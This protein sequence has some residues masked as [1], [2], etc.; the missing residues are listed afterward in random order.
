VFVPDSIF[1]IRTRYANGL[2]TGKTANLISVDLTLGV[3][4][5]NNT[6]VNTTYNYVYGTNSLS[7][8]TIT[9]V[10]SGVLADFGISNNM[11][12]SE[13]IYI[14]SEPVADYLNVPINAVRYGF[15]YLPSANGGTEFIDDC[16]N[17]Q[18]YT[19]GGISALV[20][21]NPGKNYD[22]APFVLI[23]E[24]LIAQYDLHDYVVEIINPTA[25]FTEGEIITQATT[26]VTGIIKSANLTHIFVRRTQFANQ[27]GVSNL[28][29]GQA[30]GATANVISVTPDYLSL[31]IGL[32]A[33]VLSNVQS[34][35][36]S[37]TKLEVYDSGFGYIN[38]EDTTF[39]SADGTHSG[40]A[41][42]G[43]GKFGQSEG[44]F[45]N[46]KGQLSDT[47]YIFD[48]EYYQEYS[49]EIRSAISPDKYKE[50]L[51]KVIHV[52]GTK[53]FSATYIMNIANTSPNV[54][55]AV[56]Q[57]GL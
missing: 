15:L 4:G 51:K 3:I 57:T 55:S 31:P 47:K 35:N 9:R 13:T 20:S 44:Y 33:V 32:D 10:S 54:I 29:T 23:Y 17:N 49:Y 45:S 26:G 37:V 43:L 16:F 30:S 24:P 38:N 25:T 56:E 42:I 40:L 48:G 21:V 36:G 22:F 8:A 7:N 11:Q 53:S 6:Y 52:A 19:I 18:S 5:I 50:M 46:R 34:S 28:L 2:A 27:F 41:R 1:P 14:G 39:T 12:Y